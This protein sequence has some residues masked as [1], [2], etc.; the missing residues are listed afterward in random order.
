M[1]IQVERK[2][3]ID[4]EG[5]VYVVDL[6][7]PLKDG[8][9]PVTVGERLGPSDGLRFASDSELES[10]LREIQDRLQI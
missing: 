3:W 2:W 5:P 1:R 7:L 9:L 10:C 4:K 8:W 6:A